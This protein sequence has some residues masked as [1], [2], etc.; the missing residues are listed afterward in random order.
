MMVRVFQAATGLPLD[1]C[2]K[3]VGVVVF[4]ALLGVMVGS[5]ALANKK[6]GP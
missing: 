4:L 3:F 5:V 6:W 1:M 2:E